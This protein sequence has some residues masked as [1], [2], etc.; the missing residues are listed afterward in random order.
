M[1]P[2]IKPAVIR[3][4]GLMR[5]VKLVKLIATPSNTDRPTHTLMKLLSVITAMMVEARSAPIARPTN[6]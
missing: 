1:A 5:M 3:E 4:V 6:A 2:D